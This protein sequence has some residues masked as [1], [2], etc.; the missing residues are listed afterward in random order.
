MRSRHLAFSVPLTAVLAAA[1]SGEDPGRPSCEG[2]ACDASAPLETPCDRVLADHSGR[3]FLPGSSG[4]DPLI[5]LVYSDAK[6][7][8]PVTAEKIIRLLNERDGCT[9]GE[10]GLRSRAISEQAQLS[11]KIVGS[12]YR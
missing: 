8:C 6:G 3:G 7:G 2:G 1:C 9:Q 4:D 5:A 12:S 10:D 11:G